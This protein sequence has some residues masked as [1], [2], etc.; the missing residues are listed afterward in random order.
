M[1]T[2]GPG[3]IE[4]RSEPPN[5]LSALLPDGTVL[6]DVRVASLFPLRKPGRIV[7]VYRGTGSEREEIGLITDMKSFCDDQR[8]LLTDCLAFSHFLPEI[9]DVIRVTHSAGVDE[10]VVETDR[11]K[12]V[13]YLTDRRNNIAISDDGILL[14]TDIDKCRYRITDHRRMRPRSRGLIERVLP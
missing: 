5:R 14:I 13:F 1:K 9:T 11:G 10:W 7:S 8:K 4:F 12:T 2:L 3:D 6:E